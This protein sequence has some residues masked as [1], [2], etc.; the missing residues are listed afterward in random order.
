MPSASGGGE[1]LLLPAHN[2]SAWTGS[3]GNNTW[4]LR[5]PVPTL[6]DAGVGQPDHLDALAEA[7]GDAPLAQVLITHGHHDHASGA[8]AI[9]SRWPSAVIRRFDAARG[10]AN[11]DVIDAGGG[12][13]RVIHT[14]GHAPDHSCFETID[15]VALFCGDMA[16][17]GGTVVIPAS[18]GGDL[19]LYLEALRMLAS[20]RARR[21]YPGHGPVIEDP[22]ALVDLYL[23]HRAT[24]DEQILAALARGPAT[25]PGIVALVYPPMPALIAGAAQDT[26]LAHLVKLQAEGRVISRQGQWLRK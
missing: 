23:R 2:A 3:T 6:I 21:W 11:G 5:G 4:L 1:P 19:R 24:R 12:A 25:L 20:R 16:R 13:L 14:P 10:F 26:V 15:G 7:L 18:K 22:R 8:D 17:I 9:A